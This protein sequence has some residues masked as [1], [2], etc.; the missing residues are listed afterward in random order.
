M[1]ELNTAVLVI[2]DEKMV[3]DN[4]EEILVPDT[5]NTSQQTIHNA[6]NVL[7]DTP[8]SIQASRA[9]NIPIF[10][11]DKASNGMEGLK[12]VISSI[13]KG[14][15]YAV[16]FID[17]RMPGWSGLETAK[18]IRK[19][20]ER[21]EI[22]FIT[23]YSDHSIEEIIEQAGLNVGYHCKPYVP[24]VIVQLAT[25]AVTDYNK[26]RN[27]EGLMESISSIGLNKNQL[28]VLLRNILV[29]LSSSLNSEIA[30]IG[31]FHADLCYEKVLSIGA[32]EDYVDVGQLVDSIKNQPIGENEVLQIGEL[33]VARL[34]NYSIF[35]LLHKHEKLQTEKIYL[36]KI[37]VQNAAQAIRN[38]ELQERLFQ[39]EKLSAV[40]QVIGM[41]MHDLR[42]PV[43]NIRLITGMIRE[44]GC[45][46]EM[47]DM[48]EESA[49]QASE[50]FDDFLDFIKK[51]Q[52][53]KT[54]ISL[55]DV[56]HEALACTKTRDDTSNINFEVEIDPDLK[57]CGDAGKLR[58]SFSN[59]LNNSADAL[60]G[61][62][63]TPKKI[64]VTASQSSDSIKIIIMD[65][66]PGIPHDI[67]ETIFE[68][69][70]TKNKSG[71][72]GLGLAIVRQH[73]E[74]HGGAIRVHN[75]NGAVFTIDLPSHN[76]GIRPG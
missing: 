17:M 40:G 30:L 69:F 5:L 50:I 71:G 4:I 24:E 53:K 8:T 18:E 62:T 49:A 55:Y 2:D 31:K 64:V 1:N 27:L 47:L 35:A 12:Q 43:K 76:S 14:S 63:V 19:H 44:D 11:V 51:T 72:T 75:D 67:M 56:I 15:P 65:S 22:I 26:L 45:S 23:A 38:A 28:T 57:I 9:P 58:R 25:K 68:P 21:A 7:F 13:K 36:L 61:S 70:V 74:A 54:E 34:E 60:S 20:D 42:T 32:F 29:Q 39:N 48:I 66:G 3:R 16:I 46:D 73:I 41:V 52:I 33:V 6:V 59:L 37:F 10:S